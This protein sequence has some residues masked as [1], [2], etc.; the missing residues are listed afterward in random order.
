MDMETLVQTV[1][2]SHFLILQKVPYDDSSAHF[3][4]QSSCANISLGFYSDSLNLQILGSLAVQIKHQ[5]LHKTRTGTLSFGILCIC[6][7]SRF[8]DP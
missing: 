7:D 5:K 3:L 1:Q 2:L 6:F 8:Y 4:L